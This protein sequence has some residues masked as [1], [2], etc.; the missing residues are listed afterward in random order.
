MP[1]AGRYGDAHEDVVAYKVGL[2]ERLTFAI[3]AF[4]YEIGI[5]IFAHT[6]RDYH[7][8]L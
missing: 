8:I 7:E 3:E 1:P 6:N 5:L 2:S 4:K